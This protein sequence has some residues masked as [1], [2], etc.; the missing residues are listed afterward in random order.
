MISI[1]GPIQYATGFFQRATA[2]NVSVL[3]QLGM[4]LLG[5]LTVLALNGYLLFHRGQ[6]IGKWIT[7]I[8]IVD[9]ESGK[10]LPF[11]RV[12]VYRYL[13]MLP[14]S[15]IVMFIPGTVDDFLL[16]LVCLV[17][18][19]LI[20]RDSRRCLHDEIAGSKVVLYQEGRLRMS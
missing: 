4:G 20:F 16:N 9:F 13:W 11:L 1:L 19:L 12:Y 14:L 10:L 18:V 8:Q 5:L 17:G 15:I 3:E 7:K 2:Q 6:T